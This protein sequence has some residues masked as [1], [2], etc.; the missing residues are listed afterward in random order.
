MT[1]SDEDHEK[2]RHSSHSEES[3]DVDDFADLPTVNLVARNPWYK[4]KDS[5]KLF[6]MCLLTFGF[7]VAELVVGFKTGSLA[8]I[9]D[10]FHMTSD[11]VALVVAFAAIQFS[12]KSAT[13]ENTFGWQRAEVI[14][15]F[16]NG[17]F[18]LSVCL[19]VSLEAIQRFAEFSKVENPLL[20]VYVASGGLGMNLFGMILFSGGHGHSHGGGGHGHKDSGHPHG[21]SHGH[22]ESDEHAHD[23]ENKKKKGGPHSHEG[24]HGHKDSGHSHKHNHSHDGE[25]KLHKRKKARDD[26]IQAVFLHLAGD[27]LGS[28]AAIVSGLVIQFVPYD[29]KYYFDPALSLFIVILILI[30]AIPLV[31]RCTRIFMQKVPDYLDVTKLREELSGVLGVISIHELHVWTLI[32]N[33]SIGSVHISC[34][35]NVNFMSTAREIKAIFHKHHIHSTTIQPEFLK[36]VALKKKRKQCQLD[37]IKDEECRTVA[38]C[39]PAYEEALEDETLHSLLNTT[40]TKRMDY[41]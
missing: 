20:V 25:K 3:S 24:R 10:A 17:I 26:N 7:M 41:V 13:S 15:S 34:L 27:F 36:P 33:K 31:M 16:V 2:E 12:S 37:C 32:G 28:I 35:D 4:S 29:W 40:K 22:K 19:F 21:G 11:A 18:L 8:L 30:S 5:V 39:P 9:G 38:C 1:S 14:G 23:Q 6:I